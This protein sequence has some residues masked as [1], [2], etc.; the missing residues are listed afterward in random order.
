MA[1]ELQQLLVQACDVNRL[2]HEAFMSLRHRC[3]YVRANAR[4]FNE[5]R[6][7]GGFGAAGVALVNVFLQEAS[8]TDRG[9]SLSAFAAAA[10]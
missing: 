2:A 8:S 4:D 7:R 3:G 5:L 6:R 10:S 1:V 9:A